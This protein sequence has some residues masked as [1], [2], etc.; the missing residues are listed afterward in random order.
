M[1]ALLAHAK[2]FRALSRTLYEQA[3][4]AAK[5]HPHSTVNL[6]RFHAAACLGAAGALEQQARNE[7][8]GNQE[9]TI[10]ARIAKQG[11]PRR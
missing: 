4:E 5:G 8:T 7:A 10:P 3:D 9:P 11:R 6:L 1:S 2:A